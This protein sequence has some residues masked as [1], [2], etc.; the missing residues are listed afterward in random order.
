[1]GIFKFK[2]TPRG[3]KPTR[4]DL[5]RVI[6]HGIGGT[7]MYTVEKLL[8]TEKFRRSS[9]GEPA[10]DIDQV[11]DDD[12]QALVDYVIY[13]SWRGELERKQV[14]GAILDGILEEEG[15]RIIDSDFGKKVLANPEAAKQEADLYK[16][17]EQDWG[18]A[19]DYV[20][21][22]GESWLE[23]K[24]NV[25]KVPDPP[26]GF[27][28]AESY[29]D[30]VKFRGSDKATEFD[31]S[32]N[33]GQQ[34][35]TGTIANC[36]K[37]H[38]NTGLGNGQTAD[39][40]DWTKDWTTRAGLKPENREALIPLL[41]RGALPP[42]HAIPRNFAEGIFRGGSSSKDL[43]L[44]ITQGIDGT[45][46]PAVTFVEGQFGQD[47]VWHLINFIRSLQTEEAKPASEAVAAPSA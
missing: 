47:D 30:V 37:C 2:S 19:K 31:A 3:Y 12:V 46:M 4:D 22:I 9:L 35:F 40:D 25:V 23:A 6:R 29:A 18:Y 27:P 10:V 26:T 43:Y 42:L 38:G 34:L 24:D 8:E 36:S 5:A 7:N 32:V 45:P 28:L 44:R 16:K 15:G 33:R 39:Y 41:A 17:Y 14:D 13:L 20:T 1:M 21:E 11:S